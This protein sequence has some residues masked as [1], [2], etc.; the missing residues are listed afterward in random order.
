[1]LDAIDEIRQLRDQG[2]HMR[3]IGMRQLMHLAYRSARVRLREMRQCFDTV[4]PCLCP[5]CRNGTGVH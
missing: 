2:R 4:A 3:D 5:D 1:M